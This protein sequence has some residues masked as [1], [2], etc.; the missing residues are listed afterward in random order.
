M[1]ILLIS[2]LLGLTSCT[3]AIQ[4]KIATVVIDATGQVC[5]EESAQLKDP[6]LGIICATSEEILKAITVLLKGPPTAQGALNSTI[7]VEQ[8]NR[9]IIQQIIHQRNIGE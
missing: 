8:L 2:C 5:T 1:K 3:P 6:M 4:K 9:A 7:T